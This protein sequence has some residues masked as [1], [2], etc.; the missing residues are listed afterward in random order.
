MVAPAPSLPPA[1]LCVVTACTPPWAL[2]CQLT[3]WPAPM[4][5]TADPAQPTR[6]PCTQSPC[7]HGDPR[8]PRKACPGPGR[9]LQVKESQGGEGRS[10]SR[11]WG[12]LGMAVAP[13]STKQG[14]PRVHLGLVL[15]PQVLQITYRLF[16]FFFGFLDRDRNQMPTS[17]H[18]SKTAVIK[19]IFFLLFK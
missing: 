11:W 9:C 5:G 2:C 18:Y 13:L 12:Q 1:R 14:S 6:P 4:R 8:P 10:H 15:I 7:P 17:V 19:S 16:F 3:P